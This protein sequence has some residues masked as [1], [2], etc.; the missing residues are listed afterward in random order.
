MVPNSPLT[1]F[2]ALCGASFLLFSF[3]RGVRPDKQLKSTIQDLQQSNTRATLLTDASSSL[4]LS[5]GRKRRCGSRG[6]G[7]I[8]G[9]HKYKGSKETLKEQE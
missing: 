3:L 5:A 4:G 1:P 6:S 7:Y 2:G 9:P 8:K